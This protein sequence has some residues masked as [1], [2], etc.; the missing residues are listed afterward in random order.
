MTT[1]RNN[2]KPKRVRRGST[3]APRGSQKQK[4]PAGAPSGVPADVPGILSARARLLLLSFLVLFLELALIRWTG[5]NVVY[6][7]YFTNFILLGTFL[8]VGIGFLKARAERD[9]FRWAPV[10]L[11]AFIVFVAV[12]APRVLP[13]ATPESSLGRPDIVGIP[14][15]ITLPVL[16]LGV[17]AVMALV[18][19]GLGRAFG[20]LEPLR[21]YRLDI[22]GSIIGIGAFTLMSFVGAP[23]LAWGVVVGVAF[24]VLLLPKFRITVAA[25]VVILIV[26]GIDSFSSRTYYSPYYKISLGTLDSGA[27]F[28]SLNGVHHQHIAPISN[29]KQIASIYFTQFG[30][31]APPPGNILIIGAGTGPDVAYA[32]QQNPS[33]IDAVEI[34]PRLIQI[35]KDLNPDEP[36]QDPRV[37]L[38][39]EDGRAFLEQA[40]AEYD[41]IMFALPDSLTL[42]PGQSALRLEGYLMTREAFEE[43]KSHLA[44]GGTFAFLGYF[45]EVWSEDRAAATLEEVFDFPPCTL[46]P[47][48]PR[49]PYGILVERPDGPSCDTLWQPT[50]AVVSPATD[51]RPFPY[52]R[53][54]SIPVFYPI[55]LGIM[56]LVS[57]VAVRLA[58]G[59]FKP[60][61]G[62]LDLFFMGAAFLLLE[63]KNIV[64]FALYFGSTWFV[65]ALVIGGILLSVL[66]GI[67]VSRRVRFRRPQLLYVA[68]FV[69]LAAAWVVP[70]HLV[71][72]L[73]YLLR[74]AAAAILAFAPIFF[75]NL[76]FSQRF[77]DAENSTTAFGANLL[78]AMVGGLI[79][80]LA[81][82]TGYRALLVVAAF[83]YALAFVF[84][85]AYLAD[86]RGKRRTARARI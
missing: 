11:A 52:L 38:H 62:Y 26:L 49:P 86:D 25:V 32:L 45:P 17:A 84:G 58:G 70:T 4:Q 14:A 55:A 76:I 57:V 10:G 79:E 18:G 68:L 83:L 82:V 44:P 2:K 13:D 59:P 50:R 85:R 54:S 72:G 7:A 28:V 39:A 77:R 69:S 35:G 30:S 1:N 63:T 47:S 40:D 80:Y 73:P 60:M 74:F 64:G 56:L 65:N 24:V 3:P 42:L 53:G 29:S 71:L 67:E 5:S 46:A 36:Y 66:A 48:S 33:H 43:A 51:D 61:R 78:G 31:T 41:L 81:L 75:A 19:Q 37:S 12:T 34:D 27:T 20:A 15:W 8:G 9:W 23:P 16:F 6:L 21:A 22:V